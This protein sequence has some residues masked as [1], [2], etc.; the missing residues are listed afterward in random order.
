MM[1]YKYECNSEI[2]QVLRQYGITYE[3][4]AEK[5]RYSVQ[6]IKEWMRHVLTP[7]REQVVNNAMKQI[8]EE[9]RL[10]YED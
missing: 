3:D 2:K 5:A 6:T 1:N 4:I 9:R 7:E 8:R 10:L